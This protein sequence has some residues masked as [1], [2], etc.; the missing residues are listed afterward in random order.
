M[1]LT[2]MHF[3]NFTDFGA[4]AVYF[5][6]VSGRKIFFFV[7]PTQKNLKNYAKDGFTLDSNVEGGCSQVTVNAGETILV[8]SGCVTNLNNFI[9]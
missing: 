4:S 5:H 9:L 1:I 2:M 7:P 6:V 3:V 8:P